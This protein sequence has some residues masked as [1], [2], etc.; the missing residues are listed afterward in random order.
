MQG[1]RAIEEVETDAG[2]SQGHSVSLGWVA[3]VPGLYSCLGDQRVV[4]GH[5]LQS[6]VPEKFFAAHSHLAGDLGCQWISFHVI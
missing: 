5:R 1:P 6:S 4:G 3:R 2:E